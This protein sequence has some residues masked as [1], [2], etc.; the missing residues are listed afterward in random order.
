M[1]REYDFSKGKR[2]RFHRPNA[3]LNL[4][5]P[6]ERP[7][8]A[9][10]NSPICSFIAK[11]TRNTLRA[12]RE[13]PHLVTE[14][15]NH[16]HDVSHGGYAHRQLF[17]LVQNGADALANAS[18]GKSILVRL[19][20]THL[21]CADDGAAISEDGVRAL[22]FSHMSSKRNTSEIGRFGLGFKSVLGVSDAP[23]FYSRPGSFRFDSEYAADRIAAIA[24]AE[25]YPV[26]RLPVPMDARKAAQGD[27]DLVELM[28]WA[29]NIVRL[30]LKPGAWEDLADQILDFPP[31]FLLFVDHVRYLTLEI[32]ERSRDFVL[33]PSNGELRLDTGTGSSRWKCFKIT[34]RLSSESRKDRRSLDDSGDVP[35]WWA[36]PLDG[37]N[38]PGYFWHFFPTT[39]ASLLAGILNAPWKTNED[40]QNLL[41]GPYND[42]LI[43]AAAR[44]VAN[45]L[46]KLAGERDPARHLDALPR[47]PEAG[48]TEHSNRLRD[49]LYGELRDRPVVPDQ[50]GV[51]RDKWDISYVPSA[52]TQDQAGA[53]ALRKWEAAGSRP[54]NW[55]HHSAFT[56][57]RIARINRLF[58]STRWSKAQAPRSSIRDWLEDLVDGFD[59]E[60]AVAASRTALQVAASIPE[61]RRREE[62]LGEILLTRSGDWCAP[63]PDD[64]FLPSVDDD[65]EIGDRVVHTALVSD[66][67]TLAALRELGITHVI[68]ESR[69]RSL[70]RQLFKWTDSAPD[71]EGWIEFWVASRDLGTDTA[72]R[73]IKDCGD[74]ARLVHARARSG[75]WRT[76]HSILLPGE[77]VPSD[78]RRDRGVTVDTEFHRADL[79]L[80]ARLGVTDAPRPDRELRGDIRFGWYEYTCRQK[81][82]ARDLPKKPHWF[83]LIFDSTVGSGPLE[84]LSLLSDEGGARYTDALLSLESTFAEWTMR[85]ETQR[86]YPVLPCP[87]PA[88]EMLREHGRIRCG[89]EIV[90]MADA[91]G[92]HPAN[93]AA[94]SVLLSHPMANRIRK[95]FD[96]AEPTVEPVGEEDA[97][98]L[99]DAW[100]GLAPHLGTDATVSS[101]IRC[102]RLVSGSADSPECA[103][104]DSR[105]YLVRTDDEV[106]DLR[107]VTQQLGLDLS[108]SELE[109]IRR[110]VAP[111]EIEQQRRAIRN[112]PTDA[113]R[114][115]RAV[116]TDELRSGLP[117]SLLQVLEFDRTPLTGIELA[118]AAIATYHT[119]ALKAYRWALDH[120]DPPKRW[121]GSRR[122]VDFVRSLGFSADWAGQRNSRRRPFLDVEGPHSLPELHGY[123]RTIVDRVRNL[124]CNGFAGDG[125]RRGMISLPTGSGK[126]RVAVQAIVEAIRDGF[127][128]GV[129]WVADRDELCEQAVE[130][131]RQVWCSVGAEGKRLR[132][133]RMWA[134]QPRPLP[135]ADLHV[136][137]ATVQTL[138]AKLSRQPGQYRFLS[139][140]KLVVFDEAHRSVAPTYTSVMQEVGLTR[141]QRVEEPF[142]LGLTATPYRG[143][144]EAETKRLARRYGRNRLDA[145]A[146]ASD[147]PTEVVRE[148]QDMRVLARADYEIIEGGEFPLSWEEL[149]VLQAMPHPAWLPRSVE[150]RIARDVDRTRRIVAAYENFVGNVNRDWSTLLFATSVEHAQTVAALLNVQGVKSRAV[151]GSTERS[152]RRRIVEEYRTGEI[153]VLVNY[154]VFREGFDAPRTRVIIVARPVYSPNLYFQMIG[155]GLRGPKNGGN[156]RCLI[157]NVRDNIENFDRELA[158]S[159]L[160]WLWG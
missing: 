14:H 45:S 42:E 136:V 41:P 59:E 15:A 131:W 78:G 130:A 132:V 127:N 88:M 77:I 57:N 17:E 81:F 98:P 67:D 65:R 145:G 143:H 71:D 116:G 68:P 121:A 36:V 92:P 105:I 62:P 122:A 56:T 28:T 19:T 18:D 113:E 138:N 156:D 96:L 97:V 33:E 75:D 152:V 85:H 7:D 54:T 37:L 74:S 139:E 24:P 38:E 118:K 1:R 66:A 79:T 87:S 40:R 23:E 2:G 31:E 128:G 69:F 140:F 60:E 6:V 55:L 134:G 25:R 93:P 48:D 13:Q 137:V 102:R 94:L 64:V 73:I 160:D 103:C 9:G 100:P 43:D 4:P 58:P 16:E 22:M 155:R 123:Q 115:A 72:C 110:Y 5:R 124:L 119:S 141:W 107:L 106:R 27:D 108:D 126:T 157:V 129:L 80:L 109:K 82:T 133:S 70:A 50:A 151:S 99:T 149:Q 61:E 112:R 84:V 46:P 83:K 34:H 10:S 159:G 26:L 49:R 154:G 52:L 3:K 76:L 125:A 51:L 95:A 11:E 29:T 120:L 117:P 30:P 135:T 86:I 47:R 63:D 53:T 101:L 90:P 12:Y 153:Q 144:N 44:M 20:E 39:T 91:L 150:D 104:V 148:L 35:I 147:E 21:Y 8:W 146:F 142:L 114:L 89:G 158:F 32:G 111:E